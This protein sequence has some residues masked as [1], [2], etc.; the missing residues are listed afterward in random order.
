M[1]ANPITVGPKTS[2]REAV[3]LMRKHGIRRLPVV[4]EHGGLIGI[5][6]QTDILSIPPSY[7][8]EHLRDLHSAGKLT[9]EQFMSSPVKAVSDNTSIAAAARFMVENK[10]SALPVVKEGKLVGI[11]TETDI[12]KAF[13]EILGGFDRVAFDV[14]TPDRPGA[15]AEIAQ[16]TTNAGGNIVSVTSFKGDDPRHVFVSIKERGADI[17]ALKGGLTGIRCRAGRDQHQRRLRPASD[18]RRLRAVHSRKLVNDGYQTGMETPCPVG[19]CGIR[20]CVRDA[21][22]TTIIMPVL[23]ICMIG[24]M[25]AIRRAAAVRVEAAILVLWLIALAAMLATAEGLAA[26]VL[27]PIFFVC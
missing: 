6:T 25:V 1:T 4:N 16:V 10:I 22:S 8:P 19:D 2:H 7:H 11:I 23:A 9:V 12:F 13:V 27:A 3:D 26:N 20:F 18:V 17:D 15:L 24:S 21:V 5:V 14:R